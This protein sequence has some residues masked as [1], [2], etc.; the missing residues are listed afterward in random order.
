VAAIG[1]LSLPAPPWQHF[2]PNDPSDL[3]A[4]PGGFSNPTHGVANIPI[5]HNFHARIRARDLEHLMIVRRARPADVTEAARTIAVVAEED[6]LGAQ[7]SVD[8]EDWAERFR[9]AIEGADP[10]A[11]WVL[12]D[13][14]GRQVGNAV[15]QESTPGVLTIGIAILPAAR[16]LGGGRA[17]IAAVQ[18]HAR[19]V[20]A[21]KVSLEVWTG[22]ARAI[23]VYASAGF[24]VEG[25]R[26][27]HYRRTTA[28]SAA[29]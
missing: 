4:A 23:A 29:R 6:V 1:A 11:V 8:I 25:L 22:N 20:G 5:A 12:E 27:D 24:E 15:T 18:V 3:E 19:A 7:P 9:A 26:R 16:G 28:N 10:A 14:E 17:L 13:E 2:A 21:H